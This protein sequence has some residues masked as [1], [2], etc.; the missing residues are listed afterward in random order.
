MSGYD[1][2]GGIH[3]ADQRCAILHRIPHGFGERFCGAPV[4]APFSSGRFA[5]F[6]PFISCN[7]RNAEQPRSA[8]LPL[9]N[10]YFFLRSGLNERTTAPARHISLFFYGI[11][12]LLQVSLCNLGRSLPQGRMA[13]PCRMP[14]YR[15]THRIQALQHHGI[16]FFQSKAPL[17]AVVAAIG[18]HPV[19]TILRY[20][21]MRLWVN[22]S[23]VSLK[24]SLGLCPC[25]RRTL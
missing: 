22:S 1:F 19:H 18:I 15:T 23:T 16:C 8:T 3:D 24:A 7:E 14:P 21:G 12:F 6:P 13:V 11:E 20:S 5:C 4:Q 2:I 25:L 9:S 10:A 17:W